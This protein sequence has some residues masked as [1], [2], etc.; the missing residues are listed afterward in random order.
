MD[1][2]AAAAELAGLAIYRLLPNSLRRY[3]E[4]DSMLCHVIVL[5]LG[6]VALVGFGMLLAASL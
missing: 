5:T 4:Y 2:I 1:A 3:V 6:V